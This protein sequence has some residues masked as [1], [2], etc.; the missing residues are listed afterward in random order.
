MRARAAFYGLTPAGVLSKG[1]C[2]ADKAYLWKTVVLPALIF[3]CG[4]APLRPSDV[5]RLD[6]LQ[7]TCVKAAFGLPRSAHHTALLTAAGIAPVHECLRGSIFGAFRAAM[8]STHP[9]RLQRIFLTSLAH[10]ALHPND[11][12]G[13]FISQVHNMCDRDMSAV[14]DLAAGQSNWE[15]V[16][17]PNMPNGLVD[18]IKL[19]L[20]GNCEASRRLLRL[21]TCW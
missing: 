11:L 5:E 8:G 6:K 21:L 18:S 15:R 12:G 7:A 14:L 16:R 19:V 13:S 17:A 20:H 1:L 2:A 9:H 4:T 3:G 10:L